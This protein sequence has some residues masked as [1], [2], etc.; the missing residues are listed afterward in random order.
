M[1]IILLYL[2][3]LFS[4]VTRST[5]QDSTDYRDFVWSE[6]LL[7]WDFSDMFYGENE[8]YGVRI[9]NLDQVI[10]YYKFAEGEFCVDVKDFVPGYYYITVRKPGTLETIAA[11]FTVNE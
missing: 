6:S 10:Y 7:C 9:Y 1:K 3:L 8:R 2:L 5:A 11:S 4:T